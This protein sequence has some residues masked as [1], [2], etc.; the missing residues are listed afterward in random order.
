MAADGCPTRHVLESGGPDP[1][2]PRSTCRCDGSN[3]VNPPELRCP[4][5]TREGEIHEAEDTAR[6]FAGQDDNEAD[7]EG[8]PDLSRAASHPTSRSPCIFACI[9]QGCSSVEST[10]SFPSPPPSSRRATSWRA[11]ATWSCGEYR[12]LAA[13]LD[14]SMRS[15]LK[16]HDATY[17]MLATAAVYTPKLIVRLSR[18]LVL[19][20]SLSPFSLGPIPSILSSELLPTHARATGMSFL[21]S[22]QYTANCLVIY[23]FPFLQLKFG[24]SAVLAG[25]SLAILFAWVFIYAF[26]PETK[27]INLEDIV[28]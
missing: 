4:L 27:G 21:M 18:L 13:E 1:E 23:S 28:L 12:L 2:G 8:A 3:F 25:Y 20:L 24:S 19:V 22:A 6:S 10:P 11:S 16:S 26:V 15:G 7:P 17:A 9:S 14:M 5:G